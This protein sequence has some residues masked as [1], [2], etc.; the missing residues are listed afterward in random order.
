M[1]NLKEMTV[2]ELKQLKQEIEKELLERNGE[3]VAYE[4]DCMNAAKNH[5]MKYKHW[6]KLVTSVDL[7]KTNAYGFVGDFL[8]VNATNLVPKGSIIVE[9]CH[10]T[11]TVYRI[12]DEYKKKEI[13]SCNKKYTVECLRKIEKALKGE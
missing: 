1:L 5:K 7:T 8:N 13:Y 9:C 6:A 10:E 2:D 3:K 4:H 11:Y 12:T